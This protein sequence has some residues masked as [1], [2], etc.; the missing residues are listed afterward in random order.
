[1]TCRTHMAT[2]PGMARTAMDSSATVRASML[3]VGRHGQRN[4][5]HD[6]CS[7]T[8][9]AYILRPIGFFNLPQIF[10]P[11]IFAANIF[12]LLKAGGVVGAYVSMRI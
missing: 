11:N 8:F 9:H 12:A 2:K 1:M 3:S 5:H 6:G 4:R 10:T 7:A